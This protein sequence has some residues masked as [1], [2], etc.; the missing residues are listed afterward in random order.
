MNVALTN[1]QMVA[2][3]N[4]EKH[5]GDNDGQNKY[6]PFSTA[7]CTID[8][9]LSTKNTGQPRSFSLNKNQDKQDCG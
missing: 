4:Q 7:F 1:E 5:H 3:G 6:D 9:S 8:V 2:Q